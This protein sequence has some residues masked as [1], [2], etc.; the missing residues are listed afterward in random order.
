MVVRADGEGR[1]EC[2]THAAVDLNWRAI[3]GTEETIDV[4]VLCLGYG[5][6][7]SFELLR[8]IGCDFDYD[9][10]LGGHV[11]RRDEWHRTSV[12]GVYAAGDGAGVEGSFVAID[13]GRIAGIAAAMDAGRISERQAGAAVAA[14]NR[15]I[16]RRRALRAATARLYRVGSGIYELSTCDTVI[17]RCEAVD[18]RD[19]M[20]AI[21]STADINVVKAYT[22]AGMGQ[23]QGR[24][25]QLQIAALI[26]RR[27]G[28]AVGD[29]ALATPRMPVR[30]VPLAA[31]ADDEI[32]GPTLF[33]ADAPAGEA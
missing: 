14:A 25:C 8:L 4:D 23:C 29:V 6:V 32:A 3:A 30:P 15:R 20:A 28:R 27:H 1:V 10:D 21:D 16:E 5:F 11:V 19:L 17:C 31:L 7:P 18:Q 13:E 33:L 12:D 2:V 24:T 26:A 9:E 22:R